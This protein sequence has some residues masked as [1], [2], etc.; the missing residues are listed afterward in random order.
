MFAVFNIMHIGAYGFADVAARLRRKRSGGN[1][2][3][4]FT[5]GYGIVIGC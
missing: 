2:G 5:E 1:S 3:K 4:N